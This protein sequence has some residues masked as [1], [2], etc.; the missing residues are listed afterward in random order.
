MASALLVHVPKLTEVYPTLG[1]HEFATML[2]MGLF[3]LAAEAQRRGHDVRIVHLGVERARDRRFA[4][5]RLVEQLG[6]TTV[7]FTLHWHQQTADV[8]REV[9]RLRESLP[10]V[11]IVLGGMTA[12]HFAQELVQRRGVDVVCRGEADR[13][14]ADVLDHDPGEDLAD[15][16]GCTW[17]DG[18]EVMTSPGWHVPGRRE[19]DGYRFFDRDLLH[20]PDETIRRYTL[21]WTWPVGWNAPLARLAIEIPRIFPLMTFRGC[22]GECAFCAGSRS[23]QERLCGRRRFSVRSGEA[24]LETA[25]DAARSGFRSL[26]FE[27]SGHP[28]AEREALELV[29]GLARARR[30]D[31]VIVECRDAPSVAFLDALGALGRVPGAVQVHLSPDLADGAARARLA[32]RPLGDSELFRTVRECERLSLGLRAFFVVG[33]PGESGADH[34]RIES[35]GREL[36]AS[37]AVGAIHVHPV[38]LEPGS[39]MSTDPGRYGIRPALRTLEDYE[40]LHASPCFPPPLGYTVDERDPQQLARD[41]Q[42]LLCRRFCRLANRLGH[43]RAPL[44]AWAGAGGAILCRHGLRRISE[45]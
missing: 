35:L 14:F 29:E 6:A 19:L 1:R 42:D 3:P 37:P 26:L 9:G 21:P 12:S 5:P 40:A 20:R 4:L 23:S 38:T 10:R 28:I 45:T 44:R 16:P 11:R 32:T 8:L 41:V 18:E 25:L 30:F 2:P 33:M 22:P 15:V 36:L 43:D 24:A 39:P 13:V 31:R 34:A 17:R 27:Y 7:G